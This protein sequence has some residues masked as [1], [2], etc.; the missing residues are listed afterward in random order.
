M[1]GEKGIA[2]AGPRAAALL[3]LLE[4]IKG[5]LS[6]QTPPS[7]A[8]YLVEALATETIGRYAADPSASF[9]LEHACVSLI[10]I[11]RRQS[12][13]GLHPRCLILRALSAE[14]MP[15]WLSGVGSIRARHLERDVLE[16]EMLK[17]DFRQRMTTAWQSFGEA[18]GRNADVQASCFA[19][20]EAA[21]WLKAADSTMGRM[22]WL[23]Q[24]CQ[25]EDREEPVSQQDLARC[26]LTHCFAEIRDRLFR[27]DEDLASLRRGYYAPHVYAAMLLS[28]RTPSHTA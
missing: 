9:D 6:S 28:A 15:R 4:E 20:A 19:L 14:A 27:F 13:G 12:V 8:L 16:L 7:G 25:A 23:S 24:L 10:L 5:R 1:V 17:A 18:L 21:A 3:R 11:E 26:V 22:A 2:V